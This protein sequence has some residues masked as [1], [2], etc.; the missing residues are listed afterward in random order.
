MSQFLKEKIIKIINK[1]LLKTP[2]VEI[3]RK[4]S[5]SPKN[6]K[7]HLDFWLKKSMKNPSFKKFFFDKNK[8]DERFSQDI[9]DYTFDTRGNFSITKEMLDSLKKFGLLVIKN[10]LP[11]E[12]KNNVIEHFLELKNKKITKK[13][14]GDI[15]NDVRDESEIYR[16]Y[17]DVEQFEYLNRYSNQATKSIYNKIV[18]PN[19]ELHYLKLKKIIEE[20]PLRGETLLHS[21]RFLP[22]FKMFYSPFKLEKDD[23]PLEYALSS[24]KIN[25]DYINFFLKSK[26]FDETDE[27]SLKLIKKTV[28]VTT[29]EN[30]LYIAFT[31]GLHKRSAFKKANSERFMMFFQY[32]E[33]FNKF[34]YLF[35]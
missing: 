3:L 5:N 10:A 12:E 26:Y 13:W 1:R 15:V 27:S 17:I 29:G 23:A 25:E 14:H 35:N 31:N 4:N 34:N 21:D 8:I 2:G 11:N 22:H 9:S 18:K 28:T 32:V 7:L 16:G 6:K 33:R 19:T 20:K 30:T 24:H